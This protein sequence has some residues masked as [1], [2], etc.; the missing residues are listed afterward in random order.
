MGKIEKDVR[1][2]HRRANIKKIIL[3]SVAV[4]GILGVGLVAPNVLGAMA[5]LGILP[6]KRQ[7]EAIASSRARLV[8]RG[9]LEYK[10]KMLSLTAKGEATLRRFELCDYRMKKP[11]RW[12]G[13]WR[14]L[15]FDIPEKRKRLRDQVRRML[16]AIGFTRVQDS[17]WLY[18]Y[19]CEDLIMLLKAD[20]KIGE[21]L[22][23]LV[24]ERM[25][26]DG[27]HR[28]HFGL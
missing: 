16:L 1:E 2:R 23:Y 25:E 9:F 24:V 11:K 10:N 4:A 19:D 18:P 17:V 5:R 15:I 8:Q 28:E 22:L 12:D 13:L 26:Y 7:K 3:A 6:H 21:D 14:V 20:F 27:A